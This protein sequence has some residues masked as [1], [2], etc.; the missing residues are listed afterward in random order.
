M[1]SGWLKRRLPVRTWEEA[2]DGAFSYAVHRSP[3][4]PAFFFGNPRDLREEILSMDPECRVSLSDEIKHFRAGRIRLWSDAFHEVGF[5]PD[6]N[7]NALTGKSQPADVHWTRVGEQAT[8][9]VKGL[10]ELSRFGFLFPLV[11]WF[12]ISGDERVTEDFWQSVDSWMQEN[13]PQQ[14]AQWLSAQEVALRAMAW[15]FA[16]RALACAEPAESRRNIRFL[17]ALC[18]HARRI[19]A[20]LSYARAQNNNHLLSEAAGLYTIG[21]CFPNLNGADRW[22]KTGRS[23]LCAA[24]RQFFPDGGYIQHSHNYERLALELYLW[25]FRLG[26][27]NTDPFP[28]AVRRRVGRA[29]TFLGGLIDP[30]TGR[31]PNFGHN[32]GA[33]FLQLSSCPYEDYRPVL[34]AL[35]IQVGGGRLFPSGPWDEEALWLFGPGPLSKGHRIKPAPHMPEWIANWS[36]GLYI[37]NGGKSKAVVRCADFHERP[38][39]ADQLH[40]DIHGF[41][42]EI[43][44]DAGS[45][46]Y[47]GDPPWRNTL[48]HAAVH[49]TVT[50]DGM[51][52]MRRSGRFRWT[53]LA[54]GRT[55]SADPEHWEGAHDGYRRL[56][57]THARSVRRDA[58]RWI[59]QD[60]VTGRGTHTVRL[61]WL[62]PD[63]TWTALLQEPI[64][65]ETDWRKTV[66]DWSAAGP[67]GFRF[68]FSDMHA[69]IRIFSDRP[70][71]HS[72][73]RAG[74]QVAGI[75]EPDG[76]IPA[77]VRGWR[78]LR[79]AVKEPALSLAVWVAGACP[80]RFLTMWTL[81]LPGR[82]KE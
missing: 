14:G 74:L 50:V 55:I 58:N 9:D 66:Q 13:P 6:W 42:R 3:N 33:R 51:D 8:G 73:S 63:T 59:I 75:D 68:Y 67:I 64:E 45:Y 60:T 54:R 29:L 37:L 46:L 81:L 19:E 12:A 15:I 18:E 82:T 40:V 80:I 30:R 71:A 31:V 35:A 7:T 32:D 34:Q 78:S 41:G 65:D 5:P 56:G 77:E 25:A 28:E 11:R 4:P 48:V 70:M 22:K 20:T 53:T 62:I 49:N 43:A 36:A 44:C 61:H 17:A 47:S 72:M 52:Q 2:A 39:H 38:A 69:L 16:H 57:V 23:I 79:Y 76:P 24:S 10:W 26:E 1:K 21:V 27:V